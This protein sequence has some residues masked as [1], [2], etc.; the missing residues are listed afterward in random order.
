MVFAQ[1]SELAIQRTPDARSLKFQKGCGRQ[2]LWARRLN[3]AQSWQWVD[4][5]NVSMVVIMS[6]ES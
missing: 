4:L 6:G 3:L 1:E 2:G 5:G